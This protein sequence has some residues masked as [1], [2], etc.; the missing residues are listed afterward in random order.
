[1]HRGNP[2]DDAPY[3][4]L[5]VI[6]PTQFG[7]G[8]GGGG[9]IA[10]SPDWVTG[11]TYG[12]DIGPAAGFD[13][14]NLASRSYGFT[15]DGSSPRQVSFKNTD[16]T[17][18]TP[19]NGVVTLTLDSPKVMGK[20]LK[21]DGTALTLTSGMSGYVTFNEVSENGSPLENPNYYGAGSACINADGSWG[22]KPSA[23]GS[24]HYV[25]VQ[26]SIGGSLTAPIFV[27][28]QIIHIAPNGQYDNVYG[29]G[30]GPTSA[31]VTIP[32]IN[33]PLPNIG[34]T[35]SGRDSQAVLTG[36]LNIAKKVGGGGTGGG[37]TGGGQGLEW[38]ASSDVNNQFVSASLPVGQYRIEFSPRN[39][40]FAQT[41]VYVA[42]SGSGV[43]AKT[44][45]DDVTPLTPAAPGVYA[46]V[47]EK[48][49]PVKVRAITST[50]A[51]IDP[52]Q[53]GYASAESDGGNGYYSEIGTD[54]LITI[55]VP[56]GDY[57]YRLN[58][59]WDNNPTMLQ[60]ITYL[61]HVA[62]DGTAT[63][64]TELQTNIPAG[65]DGVFNLKM[66]P[67]NFLFHLTKPD[68][69]A[70]SADDASNAN[71]YWE[72]DETSGGFGIGS[73]GLGGGTVPPGSYTLYVSAAGDAQ[74]T[75]AFTV[76]NTGVVTFTNP[77]ITADAVTG[78]FNI[79]PKA[80][81][82]V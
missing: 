11:E 24:A 30:S 56:A 44:N 14:N 9:Q 55:Y 33:L 1:G 4:N 46:L 78:R 72:N 60:E 74:R 12:M 20:L 77:V 25:K 69:S 62:A 80:A 52:T 16:G 68:G 7:L 5:R 49:S 34:F 50:G 42:V 48:T 23:D 31:T 47:L 79:S 66:Y 39:P 40:A 3:L 73:D 8:I 26:Y 35:I 41:T 65:Q 15:F 53:I 17:S 45:P 6:D 51:T 27:G 28:D 81:N 82:F 75:Y 38:Y 67:A 22:M 57:Q 43:T 21:H 59:S 36:Y 32:D 63:F 29:L 13:C 58:P 37:G 19:V 71:V 64:K 76:S 2:A 70:L 18:V 61:L 54:G 10:S